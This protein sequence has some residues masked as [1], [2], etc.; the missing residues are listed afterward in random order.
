MKLFCEDPEIFELPGARRSLMRMFLRVSE[1]QH[2]LIAD[3]E[4]LLGSSFFRSIAEADQVEWEEIIRRT[5]SRFEEE[6]RD[7]EPGSRPTGIHASVGKS[8]G[9][10]SASCRFTLAV[11][12][13]GE[14][15]EQPLRLLMENERDWGLLEAAA[16]VFEVLSVEDAY[17]K[18]WLVV[19]GRGGCGEVLNSL[20]RRQ[21]KDRL[22]VFVDQDPDTK[23]GKRSSTV[24]SIEEACREEPF[25][26]CHVTQKREIENYVPGSILELH[27]LPDRKS[28]AKRAKRPKPGSKHAFLLA[29]KKLSH[30]EKDMDDLKKR[31]GKDL[32]E[33]AVR[34]LRDPNIC[35]PDDFIERAGDELR[36]VLRF[37]EAHL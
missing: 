35:L 27:A 36:G 18:A 14:W 25:V 23:T 32:M 10:Q 11:N 26:P 37:I 2:T 16:R 12:E 20:R 30:G 3:V 4:R 28:S 29:W 7:E 15:A 9:L 1:G 33:K 34:D 21:K 17:V 6:H 5:L 13:I 19:D 22:F 8:R 24:R 31:F